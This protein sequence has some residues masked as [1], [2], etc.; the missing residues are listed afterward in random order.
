MLCGWE[1]N[2]R[3]GV[4]LAMRHRLSGLS[5]YGLKGQCAGD[6]HP[7]YAPLQH[8]PLYL[9]TSIWYTILNRI[10]PVIWQ[11]NGT[12]VVVILVSRITLHRN[13]SCC[14]QCFWTVSVVIT[15]FN[16]NKLYFDKLYFLL[17]FTVP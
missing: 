13:A 5:T 7:T 2:R 12:S 8:G 10:V 17:L 15:E 11:Y 4:A 16:I 3:S 9:F 1:G 14:G 6:E